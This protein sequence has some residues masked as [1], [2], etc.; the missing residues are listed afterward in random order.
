MLA[1][2]TGFRV[3]ASLELWVVPYLAVGGL[4]PW[5]VTQVTSHLVSFSVK[6]G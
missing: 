1:L 2:G 6:W 3:Q 5:A 4:V